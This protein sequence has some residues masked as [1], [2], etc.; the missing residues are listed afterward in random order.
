MALKTSQRQKPTMERKVVAQD[1][2]GKTT[3]LPVI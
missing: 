3:Y 2:Q 1:V